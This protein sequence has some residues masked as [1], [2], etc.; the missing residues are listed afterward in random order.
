MVEWVCLWQQAHFDFSDQPQIRECLENWAEFSREG[1]LPQLERALAQLRQLR[2]SWEH[3][4]WVE[5]RQNPQSAEPEP[6]AW[7]LTRQLGRWRLSWQCCQCGW[8]VA[9][10]VEGEAWQPLQ[11]EGPWECALGCSPQC[12]QR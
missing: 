7:H 10:E 2:H 8:E 6:L 5:H 3:Q 9:W 12:Q 11:L 4:A 1:Q